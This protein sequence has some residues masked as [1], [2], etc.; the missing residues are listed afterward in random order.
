VRPQDQVARLGGD[1]FLVVMEGVEPDH[2]LLRATELGDTLRQ[3]LQLPNAQ[4]GLDVSIGVAI[5]PQHGDEAEALLRRGDIAMYEAKSQ[6]SGVT[7][8]RAGRDEQHLRQ[9]SLMADLRRSIER[10]EL[11]VVFQ[12]KL[13]ISG[14]TVRHAEALLRWTHAQLGP[15]G[16]DEFIPLAERS[17]FVHEITRFVL[18]EAVQQCRSWREQGLDLGVAVNL[19]AMDLMDAELPDFVYGCLLESRLDPSR[20]I[21]EVTE[22]AVMQDVEYAIRVLQRLRAGGVRIAIDDFGSGHSSLSQL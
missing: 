4:I 22:S 15:V 1:E 10:N 9:M 14:T 20:L 18:V 8:Y 17:G 11:K 21:L 13:E 16:P 7:L 2:A 12:P 6:H 5:Y 3:P 19:S